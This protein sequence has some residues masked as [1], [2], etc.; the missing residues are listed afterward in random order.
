MM[1]AD[2]GFLNSINQIAPGFFH[3]Q[4]GKSMSWAC[5][6]SPYVSEFFL[7]Y[8]RMGNFDQYKITAA[9]INGLSLITIPYHSLQNSFTTWQESKYFLNL[10][11]N[12]GI[13]MSKL[14]KKTNGKL[15]SKLVK[16]CLN[17]WL[18]SLA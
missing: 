12:G 17:L 4:R 9:L 6:N 13:T 7:I 8:K 11:Y 5:S 2:V 15:P 1:L 18:C 10:I 16:G 14:K 3:L